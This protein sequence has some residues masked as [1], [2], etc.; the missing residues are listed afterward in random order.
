MRLST[1]R[2]GPATALAGIMLL[3]ACSANT[4]GGSSAASSAASPS[5]AASASA[6]ATYQLKVAMTAA[7]NALTGK[8]GKTLYYFAQDSTGKSAC[9]GA[10]AGMWPPFILQGG[11]TVTAG[12]GAQASWIASITR[13]DGT[14]Q[15]TYADHPL[16]YYGADSTAGDANGQGKFGLWFI[17]TADGKLPAPSAKASAEASIGY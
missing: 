11:A 5:A 9:T 6:A 14:K 10:C 12:A 16:Y 1:L 17:A 4:G 8:D 3:A 13:D 2:P 15:V 7:G